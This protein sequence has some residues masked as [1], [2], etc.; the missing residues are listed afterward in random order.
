MYYWNGRRHTREGVSGTPLRG[1]D[2]TP[3]KSYQITLDN[4]EIMAFP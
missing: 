3:D 2:P 1:S 4:S